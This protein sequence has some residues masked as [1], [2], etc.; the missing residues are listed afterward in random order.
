MGHRHLTFETDIYC[1]EG[2]CLGSD[3]ENHVADFQLTKDNKLGVSRR[4]LKVDINPRSLLPRITNLSRNPIRV[5]DDQ[6][7]I[8][9]LEKSTSMTYIALHELILELLISTLGV[10]L[11]MSRTLFD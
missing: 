3:N 1:A 5:H 10:P 4:H 8:V 2:W 11:W 6:N 7:R 9:E